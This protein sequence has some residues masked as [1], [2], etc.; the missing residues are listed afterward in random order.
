MKDSNS[1]TSSLATADSL[2]VVTPDAITALIP[3]FVGTMQGQSIQLCDARTLH[4]FMVVLRDFSNW[5]KSRIRKFGFVEGVDY[6]AV[7]NLSSPDLA[8][9]KSRAQKMVDY[10]L[11]LDMAKELSMV[12]NNEKGREARRYF[13]ACEKQVLAALTVHPTDRIDY[14]RIAYKTSPAD[15]LSAGEQEIIRDMLTA[16]VKRL[17]HDAQA[18]A[19]IK[20][21][22]KLKSHFGV[23]YRQIP[24]DQFT[25]ALGL[26]ARHITEWELLEAPKKFDFPIE[27]ADPHDRKFGN[28]WMT[29][30]VLL[31]PKNRALELELIAQLEKDGYDVAGLKVRILALRDAAGYCEEM[32]S[33]MGAVRDRL[34]PLA[35]RLST[36]S[37]ERGT[38]VMFSGKPD[39]SCAIDRHV[40][41]SQM[42]G[43]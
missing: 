20:G 29:P 15:T 38:N 31:D 43:V 2:T 21:W 12:E 13:I 22:A 41:R 36:G 4:T 25:D 23:S 33:V 11:T 28:A 7:K 37:F 8:N 42:T 19:M 14:A 5:I 26:V 3:V 34:S 30:R 6:I 35:E 17:P 18:G 16:A 10:H 24:A 32:R 9:A 39:A 1:S 40:F 27:A